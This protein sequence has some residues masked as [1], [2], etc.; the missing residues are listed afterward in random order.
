MARSKTVTL[1]NAATVGPI[2]ITTEPMK[3]EFCVSCSFQ[4][5]KTGNLA[6]TTIFIQESLDGQNW[7]NAGSAGTLVA[8]TN[9]QVIHLTINNISSKNHRLVASLTGTGNF[10][11]I[12]FIRD[13]G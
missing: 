13:N 7:N 6:S 12:G 11:I 1:Y 4:L 10:Q 9:P 2:T 3:T 5:I 8:G